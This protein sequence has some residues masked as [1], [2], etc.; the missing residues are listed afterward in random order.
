VALMNSRIEGRI[1]RC[2]AVT[3]VVLASLTSAAGAQV[4]GFTVSTQPGLYPAFDPS[5]TDYVVRCATGTPVDVS[6]SAQ[7]GTVVGVDG[8][9]SAS[10]DFTTRVSLTS[11]QAFRIEASDAAESATYYVRCLP[12]DFPNWTFQRSGQPQAEWYAVAPLART[13][14]QPVSGVSTRYGALFDTHGVPVWWLKSDKD[15]LDFT[16]LS[17][18]DTGWSRRD[19]TADDI[20]LD[21]TLAH[22]VMTAPDVGNNAHEMLLLPSGNYV[23]ISNRALFGQNACGQTNVSI[24]DEGV[25]EIS[26]D[27]TVVWSWWASDHIPLTEIPAAWC[28]NILN[29]PGPT[30]NYDT[31]H[32]NSVEPTAD[33]YIVSFRHLDAVYRINKADA[34]IAWKL[35]G[36]ARA[37]SLTVANDPIFAGGDGFRGQHDA[38]FHSDGTVSLHDNGFHPNATNRPPR[39]VRYYIDTGARR[40]TLVQ[41]LSDPG[42]VTTPLC[43][44]SARLL[45]GGD[46]AINWGSAGRITELNSAGARIFSL[47]F[48]DST[49]ARLFTY[50]AYP[51][52]SGLGPTALRAGME[53]QF[54]RGF[55][56]PRGTARTR[57]P[58]VPAF[59]E[60]TTPNS[61][62]GAPLAFDSCSPP[63]AAS[64][65]LTVGTPDANGAI[66]RSTGSVAYKVMVGDSYTPAN[67]ADV[68][69][70]VDL[71]DVR[72]KADLADYTGELQARDAVRITDRLN[73]PLKNEA[74]T[75]EAQFP[76]TVPC[77]ATAAGATGATCSLSSTFNAI[78]PGVVVEGKRA[79]WEL[80]QL[81]V[82]DGGSSGTAGA[83]DST[84][85][86]TQGLFVP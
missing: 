68:R 61:S 67:E 25:E 8:Q 76:V 70:S 82:F 24:A 18:G 32:A 27:G 57:S 44:G 13:D 52:L 15:L 10:G 4:T 64:S 28:A 55:V 46:W 21:G 65:F 72:R 1:A 74:A 84:L 71:S 22:T 63:A 83:S 7:P 42:T 51:V 47:T 77:A 35:G 36:V 34:S 66:A 41:Q 14:F 38:R 12:S 53:A 6:V 58:L 19:N 73:G 59:T 79:N 43:C 11:G 48:T 2:A 54:P 81:Q 80:G 69:M 5:I 17:N 56:R 3:V 49:D 9:G 86:E 45:P 85:F 78:V 62:H 31:Y 23:I 40:A 75:L 39:V 50:R 20:R 16:V 30:G 33:G 60:C 37:E 29:T 26:P